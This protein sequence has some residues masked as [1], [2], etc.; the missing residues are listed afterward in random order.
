[1]KTKTTVCKLLVK[2]VKTLGSVCHIKN[3][4]TGISSQGWISPTSEKGSLWTFDFYTNH[5]KNETI[6]ELM[7]YAKASKY[8]SVCSTI[9]YFPVHTL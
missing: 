3:V 2:S 7:Y 1:M 9:T 8:A 4:D 6:S 5:R